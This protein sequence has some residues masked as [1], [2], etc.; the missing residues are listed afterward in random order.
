MRFNPKVNQKY[1]ASFG[2]LKIS[3]MTRVLKQDMFQMLM[4]DML[5]KQ[6][7]K[8]TSGCWTNSWKLCP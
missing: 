3:L 5:R 4:K 6:V 1:Y 7:V 2:F 8:K